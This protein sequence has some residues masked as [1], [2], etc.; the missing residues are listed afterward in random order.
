LVEQIR[1]GGEVSGEQF[2][3]VRQSCPHGFRETAEV[4]GV[5]EDIGVLRKERVHLG[6][7]G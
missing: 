3:A 7:Q 1:R 5:E 4:D 6:K 2:A